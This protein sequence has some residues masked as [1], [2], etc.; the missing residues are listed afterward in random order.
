MWPAK[1][2]QEKGSVSSLIKCLELK[3]QGFV[4][5]KAAKTGKSRQFEIRIA[6]L[7]IRF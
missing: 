6:V 1:I 5:A 4:L 2:G 3:V 7:K